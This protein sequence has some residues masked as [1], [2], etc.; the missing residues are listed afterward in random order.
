MHLQTHTHN[1]KMHVHEANN[2]SKVCSGRMFWISRMHA[3][4]TNILFCV[5]QSPSTQSSV[6]S[7]HGLRFEKPLTTHRLPWHTYQSPFQT[8]V[9]SCYKAQ[10]FPYMR[11]P[12][13]A[14]NPPL[15]FVR[16]VAFS[17]SLLLQ[18][19][20]HM[21]GGQL[22][23]STSVQMGFSTPTCFRAFQIAVHKPKE[24][25]PSPS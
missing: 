14:V 6:S 16:N 9:L 25:I 8:P 21:P 1:K 11:S 22:C 15:R 20:T 23:L 5:G 13:E 3:K 2:P 12:T 4:P 17:C 10:S 7:P 19:C 18:M 24:H